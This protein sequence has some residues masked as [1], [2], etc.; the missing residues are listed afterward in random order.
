MKKIILLLIIFL[1]LQLSD[2]AIIFSDNFESGALNGWNLSNIAGASNWTASTTNPYQGSYH[3]Q[4]RPLSTT[5]PA[6]ILVRNIATISYQNITLSYVRRLV[7]IDAADEFNATWYNGTTWFVLE[8]TGGGSANDAG[9]IN[10]SYNLSYSA[11]NNPNFKIRFEC[12]AG[13]TSEYCRVD[14]VTIAGN[15]I[16]TSDAASPAVSLLSPVNNSIISNNLIYFNALFIDNINLTNAT[17]YIWNSTNNLI[18]TNF[19][20]LGNSSI[21]ANISFG[22]DYSGEF[23]WNFLSFD[24]SSNKAFNNTNYTLILDKMPPSIEI[25]SPLSQNYTIPIITFN[26]SLNEN[27]SWCGFSLDWA[28]NITMTINSSKTGANYTNYT[29]AE[30]SHNVIFACNDTLG[31]MNASSKAIYFKIDTIP[32]SVKI[33]SPENITYA[34]NSILFNF[35]LN[36]AGACLY[37]LN[38]GITN[39]TMSANSTNTGFNTVNDSIAD[40]TYIVNAYCNDSAG[41]NNYTIARTFS[42]DTAPPYFT[43]I[44]QDKTLNYT[45]NFGVDFDAIDNI[46]FESYSIN[47]TYFFAMNQSGWLQNTT[48]LAAGIYKINITINDTLNNKNSTIYTLIIN[49]KTFSCIINSNSPQE[50]PSPINVSSSCN[51]PEINSNLYRNNL[52]INSE[53]GIEILLG[54]E[55]Y[56]YTINT[57]ETQNYTGASNTINIVINQNTSYVLSL[58]ISPDVTVN[59]PA[60]TNAIG[61]NCPAEISCILY[62]NNLSQTNPET[63]ILGANSYIYVYNTTGNENYT[64][65]STAQTLIV[66]QNTSSAVSLYLNN[67][68]SNITILNGTTIWINATLDTGIGI[69]THYNNEA[70]INEG[71]SPL[72]NYTLFNTA[73]GLFNITVLYRGNENYSAIFKTY[74]VNVTLPQ[75]SDTEYPIFNNYYD[76]NGTIN[77]TMLSRFN[78]TILSTNGSVLLQI[79]NT[80]YTASNLTNNEFNV[81][82]SLTNKT[83]SYQWISWGNGS[84]HN[85]NKSVI[86][87]YTINEALVDNEY[88]AF[89]NAW[90]NNGTL[91][92]TG[93]AFFNVTLLNNNGSAFLQING[94]NFTAANWTATLFNISITLANGTYEY[95]W[96][97]WGNGTG[98]NFNI[99]IIKSYTINASLPD[100]TPPKISIQSPENKSYNTN[101]IDL[102]TSSDSTDIIAWWYTLNNGITNITFTPNITITANE[103]QNVLITYANDSAGN[104]NSSQIIF[105]IDSIKPQV[106]YSQDTPQNNAFLSQNFIYANVS[107]NEAN[108]ENITFTLHNSTSLINQTAYK[109]KQ[110]IINFTF[111]PNGVYYYNISVKD[112]LNNENSTETRTITLDTAPPSLIIISPINKNYTNAAILVNLSSSDSN[113]NS[114]W[115]YN[116]T[117][118]ETYLSPVYLSFPE[119]QITITAYANDSAGNINFSSI[120]FFVNTAISQ[121]ENLT[122]DCEVGGPYQQ[123]ALI[124]IQGNLSNETSAINLQQINVSI[125]NLDSLLQASKILITSSDGSFETKF[126]NFSVGNYILNITTSYNERNIN[127]IDIFQI[128]S[129]ALLILEKLAAIQEITNSIIAY[130]ITLHLINKGDADIFNISIIDIG[131]FF[132][133]N[134]SKL[135]LNADYKESYL[136]NFTRQNATSY[137]SSAAAIAEGIDSYTNALTS[138]NSTSINLTIPAVTQEKQL[139]IIKNIIYLSE[140]SLN[141]SYNVTS[142]LYNSGGEDLT[143]INYIDTDINPLVILTNISKADNQKFS[144]EL[145]IAKAASNTQ[146]QFAL[147]AAVINSLNFY[148]NQPVIS[149][150]GYGG[151]ADII[152]HAPISV[153]PSALFNS[154]IEIKN[155]NPDIGQDFILDYWIT[156]IE[157]ILNYSAGQQT[158]YTAANSSTNASAILTSPN[159]DG[160]YKLKASVA[161]AAGKAASFGTFEVI[162]QSIGETPSPGGG[163]PGPIIQK[164]APKQSEKEIIKQPEQPKEKEAV[165]NPPYIK[166]KGQCCL[167]ENSNSICD[168]DEKPKVKQPQNIITLITGLITNPTINIRIISNFF[169]LIINILIAILTITLII[170]IFRKKKKP[171]DTSRLKGIIGLKVFTSSGMEI[172]LLKDVILANNKIDSI[173]IKLSKK[174]RKNNKIKARGISIKYKYVQNIRQI[175]IINE[176]ILEEIK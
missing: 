133:Q 119:G 91:N 149:I 72:S 136:I 143:D 73:P 11:S 141:I 79:N 92:S 97:S 150:P 16:S 44:P 105:F 167:D 14:N 159:T 114:I 108:E 31:N 64:G 74:Y 17:L 48:T 54:V 36:E 160:N 171:H 8:N 124:L 144:N 20:K 22:L 32:P 69:I 118:N 18:G 2:A 56:N 101:F 99:S 52:N 59:Y 123:G 76:N 161:W 41:N 134:L 120:A 121:E 155:V 78:V 40:S 169:I 90:D 62:K 6:S 57:S 9:Y 174:L 46:S 65:K 115:L 81:G 125:F 131:S 146:H 163:N 19:T 154:I 33:T 3:V 107:V 135:S 24:N 51:N 110:R 89:S 21:T 70:I 96:L 63:K 100:A 25:L 127:C 38:N 140:T 23:H 132:Q 60:E 66:N 173:K 75:A 102:N 83:Y 49:K 137:Y 109:N 55:T 113:L 42:K 172:G 130:N 122:M 139:I 158:I 1:T 103:G 45:Q 86:R 165:C 126:L 170:H 157:E 26:I 80:N 145:T 85:I 152:V 39:Y 153:A 138:A 151:P 94:T 30:G 67:T 84:S 164:P 148:S 116:G 104:I 7:G 53:N 68:Q 112:I 176:K 58:S 28:E 129:P 166:H 15:L 12:T 168:T 27:I 77:S 47:W 4:S 82:I 88:P 147:G 93:I 175:A 61:S 43:L 156:N 10:R 35:T 13:A 95:Q 128:G 162:S 106:S 29:M 71:A 142:A 34:S 98:H 117:A 37:S 5:Q 111:L 87:Y 50:Y